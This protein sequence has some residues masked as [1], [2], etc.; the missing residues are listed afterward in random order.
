[1]TIAWRRFNCTGLAVLAF[2]LLIWEV[3]AR[4]NPG[5]EAYFPPASRVCAALAHLIVSGE[6]LPDTARTLS[7]Y[8]RSYALAT[9]V[10]VSLGVVLGASRFAY[11]LFAIIIE[12]LR[13]MPSVAT[14]PVAILF[15]GVGDSMKIAVA[16]YG[17][18]WPILINTIDGVRN[19]DSTLINTGRAL[20]LSRAQILR[21]IALPS[22]LPYVVT[23][24]RIS[25]PIA[26]IAIT[27]SE[28]I[29]GGNGLGF[30]ILDEQQAFKVE[31]MY[32]GI[33]LVSLLGYL[34]NRV[35]LFVEARGLAWHKQSR[36]RDVV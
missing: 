9:A 4:A 13:P 36:A 11:S 26:L 17:T 35:F 28:M 15:L 22:A 14:I 16:T 30:F 29:A 20:G 2:C 3:A 8:A 31:N 33:V 32:A 23:G 5:F 25:L 1:M 19:I 7:R 10:A 34:L 6:I 12:F 27:A 24:L 21:K 18:A